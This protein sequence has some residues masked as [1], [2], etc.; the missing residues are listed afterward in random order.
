MVGRD[1]IKSDRSYFF[2]RTMVTGDVIPFFGERR[3]KDHIMEEEYKIAVQA[4]VGFAME[5]M[6]QGKKESKFAGN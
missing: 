1:S 6:A 5:Q 2:L 3:K 4:V